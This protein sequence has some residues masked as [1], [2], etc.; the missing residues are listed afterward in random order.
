MKL[1][2]SSARYDMGRRTARDLGNLLGPLYLRWA[3]PK[4]VVEAAQQHRSQTLEK[5]ERRLERGDTGRIDF[6]GHLVKSDKITPRELM[7]NAD[8]L[9]LA[10]S[11]TTSTALTGLTWYLI[12]NQN[13]LE[14]LTTELHGAF[15]SLDEITSDAAAALPY[16][17]ACIE[18]GLR[19]FPPAAF[20]LPRDSPGAVIDGHYIPEGVIVGVENYAMHMDPRNWVAPELFRPERWIGAGIAGDDKRASQPFSTGPRACLGV[21]LAYMEMRIALA[22]LIWSFELELA[23]DIEDWNAVCTNALLWGKPPLLVKFH[24]RRRVTVGGPVQIE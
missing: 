2:L 8:V 11:E 7:G 4:G 17:N 18:E 3:F 5:A 13:C 20:A 14:A 6:F 9:I 10:G 19:V 1:V 12:K 22:K 24:P 23:C 16:L 15:T 21:N